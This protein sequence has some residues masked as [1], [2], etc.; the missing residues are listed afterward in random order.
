M[1]HA[2]NCY[3]F[4][5]FDKKL[6]NGTIWWLFFFASSS[7]SADLYTVTRRSETQLFVCIHVCAMGVNLSMSVLVHTGEGW[8]LLALIPF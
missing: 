3:H 7:F 6:W 8:E 4:I 1:G 5:W 2:H